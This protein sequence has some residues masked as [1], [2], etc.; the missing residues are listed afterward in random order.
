[1]LLSKLRP[2]ATDDDTASSNLPIREIPGT[3][4]LPFIG[5]I[6]DR[7]NYF[8][9]EGTDSF[10]QNRIDKYRSTVFRFNMVPGPFISSNPRVIA[11]L[12]AKS[13]R[14]LFDNNKVEKKNLFI[15]TFMPSTAYFGGRR[16]CGYLDPTEPKHA[17]LKQI[18]FNLLAARKTSFIPAF[19]SVYSFVFDRMES[20]IAGKGSSDFNKL[21]D[22]FAFEFLGEAFFGVNPCNTKLSSTGGN[23]TTKWI[24]LQLCPLITL[25]L[26]KILEELLLHTI[27]LPFC[28]VRG[29]YKAIYKYF[30]HYLDDPKQR[31]HEAEE[32]AAF[33]RKVWELVR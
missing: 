27:K 15:G 23:R 29:D 16:V 1:M 11:L 9:L 30:E 10:F 3:Y 12:D 4:G 13:F 28:L 2:F 8:Y 25:G 24:F 32:E 20:Q 19:Q 17:V 31:M 5:A 18:I 22:E 14:V 7:L 6:I 21:N 33:R 26:P